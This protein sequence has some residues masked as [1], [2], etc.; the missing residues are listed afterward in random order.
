M[1]RALVLSAVD[2]SSDLGGTVLFRRNVERVQA[3]GI[4]EARRLASE[5]RPDVVVVDAALP[6]APGLVAGLR[7]DPV[8]RGTAIVVLGRSDF[9]LDHLE[10]LE[11]GAN[12]IL[13]M[14]PAH[15]WDDRLMR[16]IHVPAR[17]ATRIPVSL[18]VAGGL[19]DGL[20]FAGRALNLSVHGL[21]LECRA[22]IAVGDD[23][24]FSLDLPGGHGT[25]AGTG[26]VVRM[27][28]AQHFGVELTHVEGDGRVR[29][30]RF[31]DS[32]GPS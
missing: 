29:M 17:K 19:R 32:G 15:D 1:I 2:L 11:A 31:V 27:A 3:G 10:L 14:P 8:T 5:S 30:K 24:R 26:T 4:E 9:G 18:S 22:A 16:L 7:Q 12:T 6:G 23:L 28:D 25:V 20:P 21:L 13:P